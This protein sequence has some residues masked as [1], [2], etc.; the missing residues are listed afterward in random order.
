[1]W[2][3][4]ALYKC[5]VAELQALNPNLDPQCLKIGD[6]L[7]LP[8]GKQ[9]VLAMKSVSRGIGFGSFFSWPIMGT[10]TSYFGWRSL[11]YHYGVD[12]AAALGDPVKATADGVVSFT[13]WKGNYGKVIFIDHPDR[14][15][16]VYGHL[17]KILVRNGQ[18]VRR[19]QVVGKIGVTGRTT[20]P[21]L[22]FEIREKGRC[23]NPLKYL[24]Y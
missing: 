8:R 24:K 23:V 19:G 16:T 13:G 20:G 22:H 10:I 11:G 2:D 5:P 4:A 18:E 15:Q 9:P 6:S 7:V 12:I 21:H 3:I 14:R 17:S 1:M